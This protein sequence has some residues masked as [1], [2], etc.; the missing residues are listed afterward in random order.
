MGYHKDLDEY[1]E[2]TLQDEIHRRKI[3]QDQGLCDYCERKPDTRVCKFPDRHHW[4]GQLNVA[5]R[6]LLELI[7]FYDVECL[8]NITQAGGR[9]I[10]FQQFKMVLR[11]SSAP[12][13]KRTLSRFTVHQCTAITDLEMSGSLRS[14]TFTLETDPTLWPTSS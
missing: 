2:V 14:I 4:R 6:L 9:C 11:H 7:P 13:R 5:K 3:L 12:E 8:S 1:E 10:N